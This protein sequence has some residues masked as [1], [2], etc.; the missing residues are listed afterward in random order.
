MGE[1]MKKRKIWLVFAGVILFLLV[2][3]FARRGGWI[4]S[5]L[6]MLNMGL[7]TRDRQHFEPIVIA[8]VNKDNAAL[9][10][11]FSSNVQETNPALDDDI[12][13]LFKFISGDI[14]DWDVTSLY[15]SEDN[16][17][18]KKQVQYLYPLHVST[19]THAYIIRVTEQARDDY[20]RSTVGL[21]SLEVYDEEDPN[22]IVRVPGEKAGG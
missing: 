20:D 6:N 22:V 5:R 4:A 2:L 10:N 7:D 13:A 1:N 21:V 9:F 11:M 15:T 16:H 14:V 18:G 19:D 12:N 3:L 17:H 8:I